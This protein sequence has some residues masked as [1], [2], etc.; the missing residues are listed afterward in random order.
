MILLLG[1]FHNFGLKFFTFKIGIVEN[2]LMVRE[3][4]LFL[5]YQINIF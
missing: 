3:K 4:N 1:C 2:I 5:H